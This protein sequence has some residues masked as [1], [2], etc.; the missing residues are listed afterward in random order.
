MPFLSMSDTF[1]GFSL[2]SLANVILANLLQNLKVYLYVVIVQLYNY[3]V[4]W[5]LTILY[6]C[7]CVCMIT[8]H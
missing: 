8:V 4:L 6:S 1:F 3:P 2:Y 5:H 7:E